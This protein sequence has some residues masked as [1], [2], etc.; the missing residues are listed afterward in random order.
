MVGAAG[1]DFGFVWMQFECWGRDSGLMLPAQRRLG[2]SPI[3]LGAY[4]KLHLPGLEK[5]AE[6]IPYISFCLQLNKNLS[7]KSEVCPALQKKTCAI[8]EMLS[9]LNAPTMQSACSSLELLHAGL[10]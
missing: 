1:F 9:V 8:K 6:V 5:L 2:A 7:C 4:C 10:A 3:S